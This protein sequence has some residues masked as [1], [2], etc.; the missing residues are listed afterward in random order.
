MRHEGKSMTLQEFLRQKEQEY[1]GS[2]HPAPVYGARKKRKRGLSNNGL[3]LL[4]VKVLVV[5]VPQKLSLKLIKNNSY[6]KILL[7]DTFL[8]HFEMK[9]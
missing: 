9:Y 1:E 6:G 7:P 4:W 3:L 2:F 5:S 8:S